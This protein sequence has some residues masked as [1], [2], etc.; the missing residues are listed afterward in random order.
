M[1]QL[2]IDFNKQQGRRHNPFDAGTDCHIILNR[3]FQG[4]C[5][6]AE[7]IWQ[8]RY[9]NFRSRLSDIRKKGFNIRHKQL[10][11]RNLYSYWIEE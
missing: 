8:M 11:K 4:A 6:N 1:T 2:A 3:L 9:P 7:F 10:E 5:T